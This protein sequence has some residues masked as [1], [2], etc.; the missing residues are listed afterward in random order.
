MDTGQ[1][2]SI[3]KFIAEY[4]RASK[5]VA[6]P[7]DNVFLHRE[8]ELIE[9]KSALDKS[10]F[11]ILTGPPGIG[12][13]KLSIEAIQQFLAENKSFNA[14][15]VSYKQYA[16][17]DDL[18]QYLKSDE[19]FILFVDDANRIDAFNQITG[20][21]KADRK[22][23]L[24]IIVTVRD[25]AYQEIG[26]LCQEFLPVRID[27]SKLADEQIIDIISSDSFLIKNGKYQQ[28]IVRIADGNPRLAIMTALLAK[29]HER[30]EAL[31]DVSDLFERYFA[32][33]SKDQ[34]EFSEDINIQCLG[35][36]SFF[37]PFPTKTRLLLMEY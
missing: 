11:I 23:Q 27:V 34:Q 9:L 33:F 8:K 25:Y 3:G 24:K 10:D 26:K 16:L 29:Q 14:Y 19:D 1:I 20:F 6:T 5:S 36:I 12:K 28:E 30:L 37:T 21:Y 18:Y 17:L 32:T 13:T 7:L 2:I 35:L 31:Q 22:G 4:N 15:C